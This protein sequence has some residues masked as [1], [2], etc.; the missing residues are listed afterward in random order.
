MQGTADAAGS[1]RIAGL[2]LGIVAIAIHAIVLW[3]GVSARPELALSIAETASLVGFCIAAIALLAAWRQPRFAGTS[4]LLL[5]IAGIV[6]A[7]TNE[8]ARQFLV[9]RGGWELGVHIGLSVLAYS[10]ITVGTALAVALTLLDRRLHR[11]QPLGWLAMLPAIESLETGMFA[12]LGSGFAVLSLA[13]FSGF[14]FVDDLQAQSLS[15]KVVLSCIAWTILA[16]LL[17]GRWRFGWRGRTARNWTLG[18]F[19][20]L[21]LAY[22]GSKL[23][24]ENILGRHWG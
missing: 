2:A 21:G 5:T 6:G 24:L 19:V 14:F 15:R 3:N 17:F 23:V 11:R 8:G 7:A 16:V 13:L 18:G 4:A 22:F 20:V 1:R 9:T 10:L 12:A